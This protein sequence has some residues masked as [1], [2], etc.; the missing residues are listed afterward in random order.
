MEPGPRLAASSFSVPSHASQTIE[1]AV[2]P[3]GQRLAASPGGV[4]GDAWVWLK[5]SGMDQLGHPKGTF[6][7]FVR[8]LLRD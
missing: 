3:L 7:P 1:V 4:K 8:L 5:G 2:T 6:P